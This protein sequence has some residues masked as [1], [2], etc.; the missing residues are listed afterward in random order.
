MTKFRYSSWKPGEEH[1]AEDCYFFLSFA[2]SH[3]Y[4]YKTRKRIP[5]FRNQSVILPMLRFDLHKY[6]EKEEKGEQELDT[7]SYSEMKVILKQTTL[8]LV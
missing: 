2:N 5:Y 1:S 4:K 8:A 6:S 7:S 3:G